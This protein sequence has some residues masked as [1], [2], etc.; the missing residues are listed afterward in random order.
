VVVLHHRR[1]TVGNCRLVDVRPCRLEKG[2]RR[3]WLYA[4]S[5]SFLRCR[6]LLSPQSGHVTSPHPA[7]PGRRGA[8]Q[9][10]EC[11]ASRRGAGRHG[12]SPPDCA[13]GTRLAAEHRAAQHHHHVRWRFSPPDC[14][15]GTRLAAEHR[16]AKHHHHVRWRFSPPDCANGTRLAAEHRAAQHHHHVRWR[17]LRATGR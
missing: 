4:L 6:A 5:T 15:N 11:A 12:F 9:T 3:P 14:A 17:Q 10:S 2:R 8:L 16:A 7:N 13:N 1:C